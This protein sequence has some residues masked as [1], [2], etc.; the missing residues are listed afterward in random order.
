MRTLELD[1]EAYSV[2]SQDGRRIF[3][4]KRRGASGEGF[5]IFAGRMPSYL[6][7]A[8]VDMESSHLVVPCLACPLA[9]E[10][11]VG[12]RI[13]PER[14]EYLTDWLKGSKKADE[15]EL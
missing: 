8:D 4:R 1:E 10:C 5:S 7:G 12:G 3:L 9:E 13:C 15:E 6:S 2:T 11:R 14:C